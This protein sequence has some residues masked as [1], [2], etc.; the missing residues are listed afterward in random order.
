MGG[1]LHT[2]YSKDRNRYSFKSGCPTNQQVWFPGVSGRHFYEN[3]VEFEVFE[4]VNFNLN[5]ESCGDMPHPMP[6]KCHQTIT[7]SYSYSWIQ[8]CVF[9]ELWDII[10]TNTQTRP[11]NFQQILQISRRFPGG[12]IIPVDF[13]DFQECQ[14]PWIKRFLLTSFCVFSPSCCESGCQ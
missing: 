1:L 13:Q 14:T 5:K 8:N 11:E 10:T 3:S 12:T 7:N 9:L 2:L 4:T 6:I